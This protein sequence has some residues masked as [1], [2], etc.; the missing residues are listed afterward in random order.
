LRRGKKD[1]HDIEI[2]AKPILSPPKAVFGEPAFKTELDKA[3]SGLELSGTLRRIKG[4]DKLKQY[5]INTEKFGIEYIS[6]NAFCV[7]FWLVTPPAEWGVQY[8]IRTGPEDFS[9]WMVTKKMFGGALPDTYYV[10]GGAVWNG[11][12][13]LKFDTP[14]EQDFF[15]LCGLK[16]I[17]PSQRVARWWNGS[18]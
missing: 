3:L 14:D 13:G 15:D 16:W 18:H 11:E 12:N 1:V 8:V 10:K 7:E 2:I 5:A 17:E 9:K 4:K 6:M